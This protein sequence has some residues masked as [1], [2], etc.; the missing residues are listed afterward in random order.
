MQMKLMLVD[1]HLLFMESLQ[2]LLEM[3]G[4][5]VVGKARNGTEAVVKARGLKPD[6]ILMD[7]IMPECSGLEALKL[8]KAEQPDIKIVMLTTSEEEEDLFDAIKFGASGYLF[9]N[10]DAKELITTLEETYRN[11]ASISHHIAQKLMEEIKLYSQDEEP[12]LKEGTESGEGYPLTDRQREILALVAEGKTYKEVGKSL[13]IKER[14]IKYHMGKILEYLHLENRSQL[15]AYA[16]KNR[17][18]DN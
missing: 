2:Y 17:I 11:E 12:H 4:I 15:I 16:S 6:I 1:D 8:I 5:Q 9:K 10:T 7:I 3:N 14:T 13:G 18:L